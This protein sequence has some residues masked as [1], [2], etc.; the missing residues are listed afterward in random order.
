MLAALNIVST[1]RNAEALYET[2]MV[3]SYLVNS[4]GN[5]VEGDAFATELSVE[6]QKPLA[7]RK[8]PVFE[9]LVDGQ[10]KFVL[11]LRGAG[12]WGP[13]WGFISLDDDKDTVFGASFGH[14][15]ET[16]G[17]GAEID[18]PAFAHEFRGKKIFKTGGQFTS[19]AIVKPGKTADGRDY[20][21]GISGGTI[22]SR[23][24]DA[25]LYASLEFYVPFLINNSEV[26]Q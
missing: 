18:K 25:M 3:D 12:L 1:N 22:T 14:E 19:I 9:A 16:P 11:S 26:Y 5:K 6:L 2:V 10:R 17:L 13:I 20:V 24:V 21:D 23:G 7:E 4:E 15:G 8:Y